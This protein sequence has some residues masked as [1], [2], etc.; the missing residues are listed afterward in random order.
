M[1]NLPTPPIS[2]F[3]ALVETT[4]Q[5]NQQSCCDEKP[6]LFIDFGDRWKLT[7]NDRRSVCVIEPAFKALYRHENRNRRRQC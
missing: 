1:P 3:C 2:G 5:G 4:Q 6:N 7:N